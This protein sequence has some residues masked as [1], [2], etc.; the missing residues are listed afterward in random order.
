MAKAIEAPPVKKKVWWNKKSKSI[1]IWLIEIAAV[2]L[3]AAGTAYVFFG[4][5]TMQESS[6]EPTIQATDTVRI[7]RFSYWLGSP[8][9]GDIIA[10][11]KSE[12]DDA[13]TH[14]K[15]VVGL[16]GE[17]IQIRDGMISVN[18]ETYMETEDFPKINNAGIA[19]EPIKLGENQYFVL[20][21]NR[22]NSEDSRFSDMGSV[23]SKNIIGKVWFITSPWK[24]V[25]FVS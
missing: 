11:K 25:G 12:D 23:E 10:F 14:I 2:L 24:S 13:S 5:V 16:P 9:R 18:G 4:A 19:E 8:K 21:D 22:N 6:M 20:G 7:N 3:L 15:R 17:T 1:L